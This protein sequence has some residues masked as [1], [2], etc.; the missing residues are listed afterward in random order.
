MAA[1]DYL[2]QYNS[3]PAVR[4]GWHLPESVTIADVTLREGEQGAEASFSLEEKMNLALRLDQ[5]GVRQIEVGWPGKS[6][7]DREVLRRLK[8][9]GMRAKTQAL[10]QIYQSDWKWQVDATLDTG[11]DILA[12]LH[13]TSE[14][15][16]K[17]TDKMT[18]DGGHRQ[19]LRGDPLR[20]GPRRPGGAD[21]RPTRR[22]RSWTF[23]KRW[24]SPP[25]RPGPSA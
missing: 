1:S 9:Q 17:W 7:L 13:P 3:H 18:H 16:L 21:A 6:E 10:V 15:R 2:S 5:V 14:L 19:V 8:Q 11:P 22:E 24:P 23:S 20:P 25:W 12:L 4:A